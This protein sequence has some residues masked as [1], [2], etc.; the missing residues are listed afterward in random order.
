[1]YSFDQPFSLL[2]WKVHVIFSS[3][4]RMHSHIVGVAQT[5]KNLVKVNLMKKPSLCS[6]IHPI[7]H[8]SPNQFYK[9]VN[10]QSVLIVVLSFCPPFPSYSQV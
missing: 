9:Q 7:E 10:M 8:S 6:N 2:E 5:F 4:I 1:M 3:A